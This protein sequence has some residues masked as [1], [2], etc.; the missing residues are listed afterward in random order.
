MTG[1]GGGRR[2]LSA[3]RISPLILGIEKEDPVEELVSLEIFERRY[4]CRVLEQ[5]GWVIGG[6][7]GAVAVL[8]LNESTLRA[9]M[10]KLGIK[11]L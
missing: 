7:H 3:R 4:I 9:R 11:R 2:I 8:G 5:T 6:A 10:R 1:C